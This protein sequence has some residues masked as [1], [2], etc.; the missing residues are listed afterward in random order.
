MYFLFR[1]LPDLTILNLRSEIDIQL[2]DDKLPERFVFV[3]GVGRHFAEVNTNAF[4][5]WGGKKLEGLK[6]GKTIRLLKSLRYRCYLV[7]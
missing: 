2:D 6:R 1:V 7:H 5:F 4:N 3:R